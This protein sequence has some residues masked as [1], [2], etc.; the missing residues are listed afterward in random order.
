MEMTVSEALILAEESRKAI[1]SLRRSAEVARAT[2]HYD[3]ERSS[4]ALLESIQTILNE[5]ETRLE[6]INEN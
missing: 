5:I 4:V 1:D 3:L 2:K 6:K